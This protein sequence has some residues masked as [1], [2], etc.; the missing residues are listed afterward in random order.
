MIAASL[1]NGDAVELV[2][3]AD[4][5]AVLFVGSQDV[6]SASDPAFEFEKQL[7]RVVE[8]VGR[9]RRQSRYYG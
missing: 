2:T 7:P 9:A 4:V 1:V 3:P 5:S 8:V 6:I